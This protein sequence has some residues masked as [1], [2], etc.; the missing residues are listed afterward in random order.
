MDLTNDIS[1]SGNLIENENCTIT[2]SGFLFKNNSESVTIVYGFD[3]GWHN[4]NEIQMEKTEKGFVAELKIL[5]FSNLNFCFRN[6]NYE[7]DNNFNSNFS[8]PITKKLD[9]EKFIINED[10]ID[11]I[12]EEINKYDISS[13][14]N[15]P[16][17]KEEINSFSTNFEND[18]NIENTID[19]FEVNP[20]N[21]EEHIKIEDSIGNVIEEAELDLDIDFNDDV[22]E[23]ITNVSDIISNFDF[24]ED[25]S[26]L[27]EDKKIDYLIDNLITELSDKT[28]SSSDIETDNNKEKIISEISNTEFSNK[29]KEPSLMENLDEEISND[30]KALIETKN[31]DNYLVSPRSLSK[32][33]LMKKK[34]KLAFYKILALPKILL[35]N[36]GNQNN[37]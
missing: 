28:T 17:E 35:S 21:K 36:F 6:S 18:E 23:E 12:V 34:I 19:S 3:S 4:T 2:Y 11:E 31:I 13:I 16:K 24:S 20:D 22:Q 32:F 37:N 29:E 33:Y 14:E 10:I 1:F 25:T 9:E 5:S 26:D 7:W 30:N 8:A 15:S 27:E